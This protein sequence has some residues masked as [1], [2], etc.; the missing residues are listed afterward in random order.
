MAALNKLVPAGQ[1][2]ITLP[3]PK[4]HRAIGEHAGKPYSTSGELLSDDEYKRHLEDTLPQ[5]SDKEK[6]GEIY[7]DEDWVVKVEQ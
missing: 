5:P 1:P 3:D 2:A 4:F 7:K 6:L